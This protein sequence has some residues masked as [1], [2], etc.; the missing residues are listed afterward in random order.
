MN[1]GVELDELTKL[2]EMETAM[3]SMEKDIHE[4]QDTIIL[5]RKQIDDIKSINLDLYQKLRVKLIYR[6]ET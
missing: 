4:K 3:G 1:V 2:K 6:V 5:L